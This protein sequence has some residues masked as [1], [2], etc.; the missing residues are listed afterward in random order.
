MS[1]N[2]VA[3]NNLILFAQFLKSICFAVL[4]WYNGVIQI[5]SETTAYATATFLAPLIGLSHFYWLVS[6]IFS[7]AS[8]AL[9][10]SVY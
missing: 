8:I 9:K 5:N 10:S 7:C 1:N 6:K 2:T 3:V 4:L